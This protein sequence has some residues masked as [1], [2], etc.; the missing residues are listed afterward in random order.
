MTVPEQSNDVSR[1]WPHYTTYIN[2]Q[3]EFKN[4]DPHFQASNFAK[5]RDRESS[6]KEKERHK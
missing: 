4:H 3:R 6:I 5:K 2:V 1:E